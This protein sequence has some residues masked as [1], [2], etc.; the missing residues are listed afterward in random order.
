MPQVKGRTVAQAW[1]GSRGLI[2]VSALLIVL[3]SDIQF[4][5]AV[6]NWDAHLYG[7]I[8]KDGYLEHDNA[9][10]FFP[11]LPMLLRA[12]LLIGLPV[13]VT[14]AVL[15][16]IGSAAS[17]AALYRLGGPW[18]AIA[19]LFA[20]TAVFTT[21]GY[22]EP[23]FCAAAFWAWER[24]R[25]GR[26]PAMAV[27]AGVAASLRVSGVFLILALAVLVITTDIDV[28]HGRPRWRD[29]L[30]GLVWLALPAGV[31]GAYLL[32]LYVLTGDPFAW[33]TAQSNGWVRGF[34]WPWQSAINTWSV[35][36]PGGYPDHPWWSEVFR[37]EIVSMVLGL[38]TTGW[39]LGRRRW[40]EAVWVGIQVVAFSTSYWFF[41]V[42]RAVLLWFPLWIM[43]VDL[44]QWTP[45]R[46]W[47]RILHRSAVVLSV[48]AMVAA[49]VWW[50]WLFF[51]GHW[52]S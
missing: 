48:I 46:P 42:N 30:I 24:G 23:L 5:D 29:R 10:A 21:V 49:M 34:T 35:A 37:A 26:W 4:S 41:S 22:T 20:P 27:L 33:Y 11:G 14:G 12:G 7:L 32:Y 52:A 18:V 31:V 15:A 1:L 36:Q 8:A 43:L 39:C 6:N 13:Q 9:T 40:A 19:W 3:T 47:G 50:C 28:D 44:A 25:A 45:R 16:M 2:L 51:T 17:A 38:L